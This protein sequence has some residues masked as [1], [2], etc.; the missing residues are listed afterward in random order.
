[1]SDFEGVVSDISREINERSS[2]NKNGI[3]AKELTDI[4]TQNMEH[5]F[6]LVN[7]YPGVEGG[8]CEKVAFFISLSAKKYVGSRRKIGHLTFSQTLTEVVRHMQGRC[9]DKTY[10]A[11]LITD[12]W[13]PDIYNDWRANLQQIKQNA[14]VDVYMID[15][16]NCNRIKT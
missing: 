2:D 6:G 5:R 11:I 9:P 3:S 15:F 1:M 13:Q 4:I 14:T 10:H 16:A 8:E 12:N 7:C